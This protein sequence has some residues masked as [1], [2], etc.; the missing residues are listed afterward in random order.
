MRFAPRNNSFRGAVV[1]MT[2]LIDIVFQLLIFFLVTGQAA[3]LART[4]V[5][6]PKEP[7]QKDYA[8]AQA[9]VV[10]NVL[11]D[12]SI[13]VNEQPVSLDRIGELVTEAGAI[14]E[15]G[16]AKL[17]PLIRADRAARTEVINE[18]LERLSR[19]GVQAVRVATE[20]SAK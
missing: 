3:Q 12:G 9:G 4:D 1:D 2:P 11:A 19:A 5:A 16:V 10:L 8:K 7:G 18:V 6:L 15:G 13:L 20:G 14:T 17:R